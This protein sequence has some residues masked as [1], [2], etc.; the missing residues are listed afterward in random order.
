EAARTVIS[1]NAGELPLKTRRKV[2]LAPEG[3]A[4]ESAAHATRAAAVSRK[5]R[6]SEVLM[7]LCG[8]RMVNVLCERKA[9]H[10]MRARKAVNASIG[11]AAT[12]HALR[13]SAEFRPTIRQIAPRTAA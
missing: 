10:V 2:S 12:C 7:I 9:V 11:C 6:S 13:G 4:A 1:M 5:K 8:R 3:A